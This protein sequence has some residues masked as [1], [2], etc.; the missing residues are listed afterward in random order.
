MGKI[1]SLIWI[2]FF[3]WGFLF[4]NMMLLF[5]SSFIFGETT[6]SHIF[7]VAISTQQ[8]IFRSS[9]FFKAAVF[10]SNS[11]FRTASPS[12]CR[13]YFF[14]NPLFQ[15]ETSIEQ[16]LT[17]L[18]QLLFRTATFLAGDLFRIKIFTEILLFRS[19]K[20]CTASTF[21]EE[22]H[23]GKS[24]F[25]RRA[26]FRITY[27]FWSATFLERLLFQKT[28]PSITATFS[29]QTPFRRITILQLRFHLYTS[30]N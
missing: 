11:L 30:S 1:N 17:S 13:S 4:S 5:Q 16:P 25:F 26:I 7:R 12:F 22:Q 19:R 24:Q 14:R 23:F 29:E 20:I 27:F 2:F 15:S 10:L 28:L 9:Y 6:S 21:S 8:L 18:G 3:D